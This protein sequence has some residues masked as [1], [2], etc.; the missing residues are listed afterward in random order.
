MVGKKILFKVP[1]MIWLREE[2]KGL[3]FTTKFSLEKVLTLSVILVIQSKDV[4]KKLWSS[5]N[6]TAYRIFQVAHEKRYTET[7]LHL[8]ESNNSVPIFV[9]QSKDVEQKPWSSP[10][11]TAYR[12]F[13]VANKKRYT[14]TCLHLDESNN[15]VPIFS[16]FCTSLALFRTSN[17][18]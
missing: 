5:Q 3:D 15:P 16:S 11:M 14:G 10:K 18:L 7:Y 2:E 8:D 17:I 6:M 1:S 4:E 12:V 9:I 13:Q